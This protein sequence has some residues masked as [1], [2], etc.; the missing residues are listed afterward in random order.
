[1]HGIGNKYNRRFG[2]SQNAPIHMSYHAT[3]GRISISRTSNREHDPEADRDQDSG[4]PRE[5]VQTYRL[6]GQ[7]WPK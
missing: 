4:Q 6:S 7:T 1:M 2:L 5:R 3:I